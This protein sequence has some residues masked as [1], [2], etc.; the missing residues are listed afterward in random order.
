MPIL[1]RE[2]RE[3]EEPRFPPSRDVRWRWL[4]WFG[5]VLA[6]M[7]LGDIAL[8]WIPPAFGN[9]Q[10]EFGTIGATF[11]GLPLASIGL[12]GL[13]ASTLALGKRSLLVVLSVVLL[14]LSL[15]VLAGAILFLTDAPLALHATQGLARLAV[16]K[17]IIKT[18]MLGVG[19]GTLYLVG[20]AAG[21]RHLYRLHRHV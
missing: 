17:A 11:A 13:T 14:L 2:S 16:K 6:F 4:G 3:R 8:A 10:W 18:L 12:A 7:G 5:L 21:L 9:P 1:I 20:G 19:F 15:A